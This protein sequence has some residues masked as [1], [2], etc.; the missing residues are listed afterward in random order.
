M[1]STAADISQS[2]AN[3]LQAITSKVGT[4]HVAIDA[5]EADMEVV[6]ELCEFLHDTFEREIED[7]TTPAELVLA[8]GTVLSYMFGEDDGQMH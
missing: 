8:I 3:W 5:S 4:A 7:G 2:L 1:Q 6:A